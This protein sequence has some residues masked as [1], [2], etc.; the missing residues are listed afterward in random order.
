MSLRQQWHVPKRNLR[1]VIVKEDNVP[2]NEWKLAKLVEATVDDDGLVRKVKLQI[3]NKDVGEKGE[4]LK[5]L[6]FLERPVQKLVVL[7]EGEP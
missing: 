1:V 6:S 7:V 5:Q 2:R 4:H 3:G